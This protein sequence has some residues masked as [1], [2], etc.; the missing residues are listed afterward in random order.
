MPQLVVCAFWLIAGVVTGV[1]S[2]LGYQKIKTK[3]SNSLSEERATIPAEV[4]ELGPNR[5]MCE[6]KIPCE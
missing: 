2:V 6:P 1:S 5:P 3:D 4:A